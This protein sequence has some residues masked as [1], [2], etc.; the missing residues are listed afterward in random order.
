MGLYLEWGVW[1]S[2]VRKIMSDY[3]IFEKYHTVKNLLKFT[4]KKLWVVLKDMDFYM[5]ISILLGGAYFMHINFF[6][7]H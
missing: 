2:V 4:L 3:D 6:Y 5:Q 7:Y 1:G